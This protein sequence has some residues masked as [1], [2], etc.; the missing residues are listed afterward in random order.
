MFTQHYSA[1]CPLVPF[2][3]IQVQIF[4]VCRCLSYSTPKT[5]GLPVEKLMHHEISNFEPVALIK[6]LVHVHSIRQHGFGN[7]HS[8]LVC[9]MESV[10]FQNI[11]MSRCMC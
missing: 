10:Y 4:C 2:R 1:N 5:W 9:L 8:K 3:L 6:C 7:Q 11:A